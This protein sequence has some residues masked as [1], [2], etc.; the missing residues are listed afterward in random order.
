MLVPRL[1]VQ[2]YT[3]QTHMEAAIMVLNIL[4]QIKQVSQEEQVFLLPQWHLSHRRSISR[5][6]TNSTLIN[7]L[8]ST[9]SMD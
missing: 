7:Y 9:L 8:P 3:T 2:V 4:T 6:L 5:M 1:E